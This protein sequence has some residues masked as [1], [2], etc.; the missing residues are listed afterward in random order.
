MGNY[1]AGLV[2]LI[3]FDRW[4]ADTSQAQADDP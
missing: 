1:A 3:L 4:I 2:M